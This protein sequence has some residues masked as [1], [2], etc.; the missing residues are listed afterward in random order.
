MNFSLID[1][2]LWAAGVLGAAALLTVLV[3]RRRAAAF[4]FFTAWIAFQVALSTLLF[5]VYRHG[6]AR[7]YAKIY[8][9]SVLLDFLLQLAVVF[10]LAAIVLRPTGTWLRDAR[11]H[12]WTI[13][14]AGALLAA[15][16]AFVV[17]PAARSS[18][19]AWEVRGNLFTAMIICEL[20]LAMLIASNRLGLHWRNHVMGLGKGLTT[21]AMVSFSVESTHSLLGEAWH[22]S[23]LEHLRILAWLFALGYW[24]RVF[25]LP[26]PERLPLSPE[27]RN[28]LVDLHQRVRYD[29]AKV[30]PFKS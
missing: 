20:F 6:A 13:G 19:D 2:V 7:L 30:R 10:E 22:F 3:Y 16:V 12:F 24:I 21:W 26:E 25:W 14:T 15:A 9:I 4:P 1:N 18:L 17:H 23:A 8:W 5:L 27:M 28:Y 29:L 11:A